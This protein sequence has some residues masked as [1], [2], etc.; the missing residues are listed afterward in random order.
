M[1]FVTIFIL[2]WHY[3]RLNT[4]MKEFIS[5]SFVFEDFKYLYPFQNKVQWTKKLRNSEN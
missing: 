4:W 3:R 2:L 5:I 1:E